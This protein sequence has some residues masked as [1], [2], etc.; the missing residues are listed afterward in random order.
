MRYFLILA[1]TTLLLAMP[2]AQA[3]TVQLGPNT[4]NF[5]GRPALTGL[6]LAMH[7]ALGRGRATPDLVACVDQIKPA[8]FSPF[9]QSMLDGGVEADELAQMEQFFASPT[10][11]HYQDY[12][13]AQLYQRLGKVPPRPVKPLNSAEQTAVRFFATTSA[14]SKLLT[15]HLLDSSAAK[16]RLQQHIA[17]LV[18]RCHQSIDQTAETNKE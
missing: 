16:A 11:L 17:L 7:D 5:L 12:T 2:A 13:V 3:A 6:Q 18:D 1:T 9:F 10:G 8:A 14:G 4:L 15:S